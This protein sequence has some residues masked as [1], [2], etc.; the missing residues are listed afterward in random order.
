MQ[1]GSVNF[2]YDSFYKGDFVLFSSFCFLLI[3]LPKTFF[4]IF[5]PFEGFN[6]YLKER[7]PGFLH[8][9]YLA[10]PA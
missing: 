2:D 10:S 6:F 3:F 7:Q 4:H 5:R 8:Y 1:V 9:A